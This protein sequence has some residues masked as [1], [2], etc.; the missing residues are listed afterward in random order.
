MTAE[1]IRQLDINHN[2]EILSLLNDGQQYKTWCYAKQGWAIVNR[3]DGSLIVKV[4]GIRK[5][6]SMSIADAVTAIVTAHQ[7]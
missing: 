5:A 1:R 7:G 4:P 3:V 6:Q 2:T